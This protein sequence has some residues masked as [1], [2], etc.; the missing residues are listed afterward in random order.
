[1]IIMSSQHAA[2]S[3]TS[4]AP[5]FTPAEHALILPP[6]SGPQSAVR[7]AR[8]RHP[9]HP[10]PVENAR[11]DAVLHARR[12]VRCGGRQRPQP[13]RRRIPGHENFTYRT[14]PR[15]G[16]PLRHDSHDVHLHRPVGKLRYASHPPDIH[17]RPTKPGRPPLS[18]QHPLPHQRPFPGDRLRRASPC[19]RPGRVARPALWRHG[20][21]R[22]RHAQGD[23]FFAPP[24][25]TSFRL[26]F[27][28]KDA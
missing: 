7:S 26:H 2:R 3:L 13:Y 10:L 20:K 1:M 28:A 17:T 16:L 21:P 22:T 24:A 18:H 19:A 5:K 12:L 27:P 11:T 25:F 6:R 4:T 9:P 23:I 15:A 14:V 8:R